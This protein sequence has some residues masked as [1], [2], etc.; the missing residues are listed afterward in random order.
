V[1]QCHSS[2]RTRLQHIIAVQAPVHLRALLTRRA[3][4][5]GSCEHVGH[6]CHVGAGWRVAGGAF[7]QPNGCNDCHADNARNGQPL[8]G[9]ARPRRLC[10]ALIVDRE[11]RIHHKPKTL[12]H[13]QKLPVPKGLAT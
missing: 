13:T 12:E 3:A 6:R 5:R 7:E 1:P 4:T 10:S 2:E 11:Y 9:T 8:S